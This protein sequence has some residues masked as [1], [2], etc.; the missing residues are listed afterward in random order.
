[1][2]LMLFFCKR[3][4]DNFRVN[5][6]VKFVTRLTNVTYLKKTFNR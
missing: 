3:F 2:K 6:G 1:M 5:Y 4:R